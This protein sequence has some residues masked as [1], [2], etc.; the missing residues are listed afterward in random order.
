MAR[1]DQEYIAFNAVRA[2]RVDNDIDFVRP[3]CQS[4]NR[5]SRFFKPRHIEPR[6]IVARPGIVDDAMRFRA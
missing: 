3:A 6:H 4:R 5:P 2:H 1:G